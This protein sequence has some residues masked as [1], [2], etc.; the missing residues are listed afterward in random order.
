MTNTRRGVC[1]EC[2]STSNVRL[3]RRAPLPG[4][5]SAHSGWLCSECVDRLVALADVLGDEAAELGR[6]RPRSLRG[7]NAPPEDGGPSERVGELRSVRLGLDTTNSVGRC[8]RCAKTAWSRMFTNMRPRSRPRWRVKRRNRARLCRPCAVHVVD[9]DM[10]GAP[11]LGWDASEVAETLLIWP[12]LGPRY[13]G[14]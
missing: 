12:D 4:R 10:A 14:S 3:I 2:S 13:Q 8:A 9:L 7:L 1:R 11:V 5:N 6:W